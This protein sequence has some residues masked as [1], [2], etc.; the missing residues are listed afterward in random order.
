M[1]RRRAAGKKQSQE[2]LW[3]VWKA[4]A[5]ARLF[6]GAGNQHLII[7][8]AWSPSRAVCGTLGAGSLLLGSRLSRQVHGSNVVVV[9]QDVLQRLYRPQQPRISGQ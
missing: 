6:L 8:A 7:S 4:R 9:I 2:R 3:L 1:V 5:K